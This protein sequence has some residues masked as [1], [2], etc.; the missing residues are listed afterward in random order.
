[1]KHVSIALVIWVVALV[2]AP[3]KAQNFPAKPVRILSSGGPGGNNDTQTRGLAQYLGDRMGQAFVVENRTGAGGMIAGEACAKSGPDGHTLCTFG[4]NAITWNPALMLKMPYDP[5]K[6]LT[7]IAH[8]GFVDS[9]L[10]AHPSVPANSLTE[11]LA[12][13][14]AKPGAITW[15]SFGLNSSGH[16]YTEWLRRFRDT[17][18]VH[19]PY[20]SSIL[21]QQAVIAGEVQVNSYAAGQ[22][23]AQIKAGKV[24]AL[25]VNSDRRLP[26]LP[27]VQTEGEAGMDLPLRTWFGLLGPAGIP[28]DIQVKLNTEINRVMAEREFIDKFMARLG[29]TGTNMDVDQFAAFLRK[30]RADFQKFATEM[31]LERK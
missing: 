7:G 18:V 11:L 16:F 19:V 9:I 8:T 31:G 14:K 20:K 25:S 27:N 10:T 26:E 4:V 22:A 3:V 29:F 28:R 5:G 23:M 6:D 12:Y 30:E 24:K 21:A 13:A 17:Q 15:A 1:M 2:A